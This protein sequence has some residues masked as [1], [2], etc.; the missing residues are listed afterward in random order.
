[1]R[2]IFFTL[3]VMSFFSGEVFATTYKL[4]VHGR[5]SDNHCDAVTSSFNSINYDKGGYW[6]GDTNGVANARYVGFDGT[7]SGGAYSW[8]NCGAQRQLHNAMQKFCTGSNNCEIYTHSTGGLVVA[9]YFGLHNPS[10]LNISRIQLMANASGGS[11]LADFSSTYLGWLGF[12]ST[13][14]ELDRS[15]STNGAR[16]GFN[17]NQSGGRRLYTTS[18]EGS[19]YWYVTSPLLPGYDDGVLANHTLCNINKVADID[20]SCP[21]GTGRITKS[22]RCGWFWTKTCYDNYYRWTPY[23]TVYQGGR[24]ESHSTAKNDYNKR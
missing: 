7:Q 22:Y 3:L 13:G 21:R 16:N 15:V 23:Y 17:H 1:M 5:S 19:D 11:E 2:K 12:D 9:A 24:S 6:G 20:K 4:F 14:G 8:N 18:G 10:G